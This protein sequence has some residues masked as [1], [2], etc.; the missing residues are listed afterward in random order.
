MYVKA[1]SYKYSALMRPLD[2]WVDQTYWQVAE[3]YGGIIFASL[4]AI[5]QLTSH[6]KQTHS[7]TPSRRKPY[8]LNLSN[9]SN[10]DARKP[11]DHEFGRTAG[12]FAPG[13]KRI[14]EEYI[15]LKDDFSRGESGHDQIDSVAGKRNKAPP[16]ELLPRDRL[17]DASDWA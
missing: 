9:R 17:R 6:W 5:R 15:E 4:P 2:D 8:A 1:A 12:R 7:L 16:P 14:A 11:P 10:K 3:Q 13:T